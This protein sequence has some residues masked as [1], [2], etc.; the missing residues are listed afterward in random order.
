MYYG[1]G[2]WPFSFA[3]HILWLILFIIVIIWL[4]RFAF[5]FGGPRGKWRIMSGNALD[6]LNER[7][8]KGEINKEEYEQKKKDLLS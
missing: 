1:F 4:V 6:V 7:Y 8:A 5:G 3:F 2:F